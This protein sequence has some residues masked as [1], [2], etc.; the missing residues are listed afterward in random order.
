[1]AK[2]GATIILPTV[3]EQMD[4]WECTFVVSSGTTTA[5]FK[6]ATGTIQTTSGTTGLNIASQPNLTG[7]SVTWVAAYKSGVS[8]YVKDTFI[9]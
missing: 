2:S 1:L 4:G 8:Y 6:P 9:Q 5:W 7:D 3:T